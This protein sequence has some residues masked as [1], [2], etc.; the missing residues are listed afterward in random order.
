MPHVIS[1]GTV[2][3]DATV[4]TLHCWRIALPIP[5]L[6]LVCVILFGSILYGCPFSS[7]LVSF[8]K[9]LLISVID[10]SSYSVQVPLLSH[11][12]LMSTLGEAQRTGLWKFE[13]IFV[14]NN[15]NKLISYLVEPTLR[16]TTNL[17]I[18]ETTNRCANQA[19]GARRA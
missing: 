6:L 19:N 1:T 17:E 18:R 11:S 15:E 16:E 14:C 10:A 2:D 3:A 8:G 7:S 5:V 9:L 13:V 12:H 4:G